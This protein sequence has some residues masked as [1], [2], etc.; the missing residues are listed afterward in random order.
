MWLYS[1]AWY[2][3]LP[4]VVVFLLVQPRWRDGWRERLGFVDTRAR[5]GIWV[6]AA[7]VG[8]VQAALPLIDALRVRYADLPL[9]VTSFT[10]TGREHALRNVP[11]GVDCRVLP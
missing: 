10:P 2:L 5:R 9:V 11:N 4:V 7:S 8:E 3:A 6:H 1:L